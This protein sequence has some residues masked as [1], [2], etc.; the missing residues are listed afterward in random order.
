[1]VHQAS[2]A[3]QARS[4]MAVFARMKRYPMV[5]RLLLGSQIN[6]RNP[7]RLGVPQVAVLG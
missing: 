1:M 6:H 4:H 2:L 3:L 7:E 5:Q